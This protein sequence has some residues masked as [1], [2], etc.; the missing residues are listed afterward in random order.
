MVA[1]VRGSYWLLGLGLS[2]AGI[3]LSVV[4]YFVLVS[5][6]LTALGLSSLILSGVSFALAYG[7][8]TTSAEASAILFEAGLENISALIEEIGLKSKAIYLPSSRANG[9]SKAFIPLNPDS[10]LPSTVKSIP[11]RLIV[12]FGPNA[13]DLG[14]MFSTPGSSAS[15]TVVSKPDATSGDIEASLTLILA[16]SMNL[17]DAARV[18]L[19]DAKITVELVGPHFEYKKMWIYD[20]IGTP[21]ASMVASITTQ[22]LDKA[23]LI[24]RE[25][26]KFVKHIIEL[27]VVG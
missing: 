15:A 7:Q 6:P 14:L 5:V 16:G 23:V 1:S 2:L 25:E 24:I 18:T 13:D 21:L 19:E 3:T 9:S 12:K 10:V 22:V 26:P 8:P 4:A 20:L 11:K 17:V 27:K